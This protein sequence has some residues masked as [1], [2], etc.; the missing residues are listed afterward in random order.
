MKFAIFVE[1]DP[2]NIDEIMAVNN[3]RMEQMKVT[4]EKFFKPIV[5]P[6]II[7]SSDSVM[8]VVETNDEKHLATYILDYSGLMDIRIEP[9]ISTM[10]VDPTVKRN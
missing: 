8:L 10:D 9:L 1:F 5:M 7:G 2:D 3:Q 4:P 6:H